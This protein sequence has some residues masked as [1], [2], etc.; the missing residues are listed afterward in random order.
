MQPL[1]LIGAAYTARSLNFDASRLVNLYPEASGSGQSKSIAMLI[2]APGLRR[3]A[4]LAGGGVRGTLRFSATVSLAVV[5]GN[6]Y[7][8]D[9]SGNGTLI[10]TIANASTPVSMAS[11]GTV[12]MLVTG[13]E[14]YEVNPTTNAVTQILNPAFTGAD[15]VDYIDGYFV[16]NKPG[17]QQ[18]QITQLLSTNIDP[19]RL[20]LGR[21]SP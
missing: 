13:S 11:N 15:R 8:V 2:G 10:G 4:T 18:F 9:T 16:F 3:F 20:R 5:G 17:T 1:Q 7:K 12:V 14:G 21:G 19:A 6:V